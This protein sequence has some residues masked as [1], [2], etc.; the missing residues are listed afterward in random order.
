MVE[1]VNNTKSE[2]SYASFEEGERVVTQ[3]FEKELSKGAMT[4]QP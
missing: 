2:S 3:V 1:A 4:T